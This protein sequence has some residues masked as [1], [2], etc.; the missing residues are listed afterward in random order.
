MK[1]SFEVVPRDQEATAKQM[2]FIEQSL[3]FVNT[4]N[5]P[6]LL[7]LPI[8]SWEGTDFVNRQQ[9]DFIPHVRSI[10]FD[11]KDGRLQKLIEQ[12]ELDKILLV[13][14]DPPPDRT[15]QV[16]DTDVVDLV[17]DIR[18]DFPEIEIYCGFDPFRSSVKQERDYINR[19]F[20]AG[21]D[22]ILSQPF[23]DSRMV[24][25]YSDFLPADKVFWGI[26]PV[27]SEK[28]RAYW[29]K[30]NNVVFPKSFAPTYEW[31]VDFAKN[32]LEHCFNTGANVY[33]M[34]I[35]INLEKYFLPIAEFIEQK[36]AK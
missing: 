8:R 29:E 2:S 18:R 32:V 5:V 10:D 16:Y 11:R 15:H 7:R 34:P 1:I 17:A 36:Q 28:S 31:N 25:V 27:V 14:G 24:E 3:P 12:R 26:S 13:T 35:R 30:V 21:C 23:F 4:V 20:D 22:Y 6:D 19:K 9:Y 33:F